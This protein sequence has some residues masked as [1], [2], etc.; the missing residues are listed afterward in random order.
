MRNHGKGPKFVF[1]KRYARWVDG[2]RLYVEDYFRGYTPPLSDRGS[3][4]QLDFGF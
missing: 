2:E 3:R 4:L 1:V